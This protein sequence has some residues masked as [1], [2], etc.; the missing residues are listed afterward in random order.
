M[1]DIGEISRL[2]KYRNKTVSSSIRGTNGE[3]VHW[4]FIEILS[5][6]AKICRW[7]I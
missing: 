3:V 7:Q 4:F 5:I 6:C 2:V 1:T